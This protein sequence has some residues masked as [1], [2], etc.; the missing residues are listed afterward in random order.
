M[1]RYIKQCCASRAHCLALLLSIALLSSCRQYDLALPQDLIIYMPTGSTANSMDATFVTARR[2]VLAG[3]GTA[4]PVLLTRAY[5]GDVQVTASIDTSLLADYDR[6]NNT[7][8]PR[9][10]D[11]SFALE[12]NGQVR[13]PGGQERSVDS[14]RV[15]LG[16]QAAGLDLTKQYVLPVRLLG[17][18]SN[19]PLSSNRAVMYLR[20][21]FAPI[22]MQLNGMPE[23]RVMAIRINRTPAGDV[24]NGNLQLTAALSTVFAQPL[25]VGL[26]ARQ[27]WLADYNQVNQ[28]RYEA[29]PAGTFTL[30]PSTVSIGAGALEAATAF[31]L[32]LSNT[33]AF[34]PGRDYMLPVGVV[35]EGPIPPHETQ[36]AAY[37]TVSVALQNIDPANP[38]PS[39]SRV[40]R[41]GWTAT[42]SSTDTQY[43]PGGIPAMAFDNNPAT[44]WHSAFGAANVIFTVDMQTLKNIRGF[45]FTP[46]YW[47]YF[48]SVFVSAVTAMEVSSSNDGVN[49]L[50]QGSY[51]GSMP[52]GTASNP[53]LRNLS[54]YTA[55]QAR[56]FRFRITQYGQYMPGFGELYAFE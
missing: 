48:S 16:S 42:A 20:I 28:T 26:A 13:I 49:W 23:N 15:T 46:R 4:F 22:T 39:G 9:F 53:Q 44:G 33:A 12:G 19:L 37:F 52:G 47:N 32:A 8:S 14:L 55:V 30:N 10:P 24:V 2:Q 35:D 54:F 50:V 41:S 11:G 36:G 25:S 1:K 51:S 45:S 21:R 40:D 5:D 34:E 43:A 29:F 38:A 7:Q 56:Y 3:S 31:S 27:D 17:T 6:Q 18:D